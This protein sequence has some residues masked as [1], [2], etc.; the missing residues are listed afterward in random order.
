MIHNSEVLC[1][2]Q[3]HKSL[4]HFGMTTDIS[5]NHL[6]GEKCPGKLRFL[7]LLTVGKG[8]MLNWRFLIERQE[9]NN[10]IILGLSLF[11][12]LFILLMMII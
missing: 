8:R 10:P 4:G 11:P 6:Y 12:V 1:I 7:L 3:M 5:Q 2:L 9:V